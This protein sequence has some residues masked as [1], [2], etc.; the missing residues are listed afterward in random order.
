MKIAI[1]V[2]GYSGQKFDVAEA[3]RLLRIEFDDLLQSF[4][5]EPYEVEVVS[6]YTNIGIPEIAFRLAKE[7]GFTTR[8]IANQKDLQPK[9][10]G[11]HPDVNCVV[12][13]DEWVERGQ[14]SE[15]F[16]KYCHMFVQIGGGKQSFA[17]MEEAA[18][19][20]KKV[21]YH[22]LEAIN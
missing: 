22:P 2:V 10:N 3:E 13:N 8:A 5:F 20:G 11:Q 1:G 16:V 6:G 4:P 19:Q 12:L 9:Y 14:E 21:I 7:Y 17:E 15:Y 18:R